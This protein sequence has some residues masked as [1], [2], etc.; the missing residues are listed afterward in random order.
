MAASMRT[1]AAVAGNPRCGMP[2]AMCRHMTT[3]IGYCVSAAMSHRM[4]ATM[5]HRMS[6]GMPTPAASAAAYVNAQAK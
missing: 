1:A 5:S 4:S 3:A 6:A 2:A